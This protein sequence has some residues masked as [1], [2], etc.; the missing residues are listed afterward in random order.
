MF[1]SLVIAFT[2][3]LGLSQAAIAQEFK[4]DFGI[5]SGDPD[6]PV[7]VSADALSIDQET[8]GA[9]F[10]GN[11]II[12]QGE[13]RMEADLV[14]VFYTEDQ[15]GIS[16]L[17]GSGGVSIFSGKDTAKAQTAEYDVTSGLIHMNGN[18][19]LVQGAN[20]IS[21]ERMTV[22]TKNST[23]ELHGRVRTVLRPKA[24]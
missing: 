15:S 16:R 10:D 5:A 7:E 4:V 1:R 13:M 20:S 14:D 23:A 19:V 6:A 2:L 18:V 9:K 12:T 8:G 24:N 22:N 21:S 3:A 17:V 11:V